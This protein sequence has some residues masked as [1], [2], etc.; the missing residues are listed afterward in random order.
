MAPPIWLDENGQ[1]RPTRP[2]PKCG[3]P[4]PILRLRYE[5]L[6]ANGW[7]PFKLFFMTKLVRARAR[8]SALASAGRLLATGCRFRVRVR[9]LRPTLRLTSLLDKHPPFAGPTEF[10]LDRSVE[11]PLE[12]G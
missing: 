11:S 10:S 8:V 7:K 1:R 6:R 5:H 3:L 2:C 4:D 12:A 9:A